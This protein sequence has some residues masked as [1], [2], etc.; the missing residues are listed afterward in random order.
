MDPYLLLDYSDEFIKKSYELMNYDLWKLCMYYENDGLWIKN[1]FD[2]SAN[3]LWKVFHI[4]MNCESFSQIL[5]N[6]CCERFSHICMNHVKELLYNDFKIG[7]VV[8]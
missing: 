2:I 6:F 4:V 1:A 8:E 7:M 5:W 3:E